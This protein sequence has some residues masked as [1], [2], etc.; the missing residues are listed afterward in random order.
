MTRSTVIRALADF[1]AAN[2]S[3]IPV[4]RE[5]DNEDAGAFPYVLVRAGT[6]EDMGGEQ[7][8]LWEITAMVGAFHDAEAT[9]DEV[10]E[11]QAEQV[12]ALLDDPDAFASF[13]APLK[14]AI[15]S[16]N[17]ISTEAQLDGMTW[18]HIAAFQIIA[19]PV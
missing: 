4:L 10:A 19:A 11:A 16:L 12:F 2:N 1:L 5:V 17:H 3:P 15:S 9:T 8:I 7:A 6:A 13:A 14:L 18:R